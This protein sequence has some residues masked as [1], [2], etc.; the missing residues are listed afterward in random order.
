[1]KAWQCVVCRKHSGS[2]SQPLAA[3]LPLSRKLWILLGCSLGAQIS[4]MCACLPILHQAMGQHYLTSVLPLGSGMPHE[5][6]VLLIPT[7]HL[8]TAFLPVACQHLHL[9]LLSSS[10][11][12]RVTMKGTSACVAM[13]E[14]LNVMCV[15]RV[16]GAF[17][18][19]ILLLLAHSA[20]FATRLCAG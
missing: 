5:Q 3:S 20:G 10:Q 13:F 11:L 8:L 2:S 1:M 6:S 14:G 16:P 15:W 9:L 18:G 17:L 4:L 19:G 12:P 7:G